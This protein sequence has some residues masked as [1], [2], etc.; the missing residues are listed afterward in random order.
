MQDTVDKGHFFED[1]EIEF[2]ITQESNLYR[3]AANLCRAAA[4]Q[5]AKTASVEDAT[6]TFDSKKAADHYLSLAKTYDAKANAEEASM[7]D[8]ES[9]GL[10]LPSIGNGSDSL[11]AFT[12]G[13]HFS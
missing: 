9:T 2:A 10:S 13:L 1:G 3:V 8:P 5:L 12:R 11:P 6:I 7:T 4:A